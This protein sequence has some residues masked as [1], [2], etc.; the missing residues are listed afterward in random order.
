MKLRYLLSALAGIALLASCTEEEPVASYDLALKLDKS[1]V[2]VGS[3]GGS[4]T[5]E[6]NSGEISWSATCSADWVQFSPASGKGTT[7]VTVTIGASDEDRNAEIVLKA[8]SLE[9]LI[10]IIQTGNPHGLMEDD[11]LTCAEAA[12]ICLKLSSGAKTPKKY[13]VKGI[14]SSVVEAYGTQYGNGTW[15]MSDNGEEKTFEVYRAL[16]LNNEK[17]DDTSKQNIGEGDEVV[18][19][20]LLTNYNG[21]A[22]TSQNEAYLVS[23]KAGTDPVLS[24][25]EATKT[26][27]AAAEAATFEIVC[28]NLTEGWTVTGGADWITEFTQSGTKDDKEIKVKFA[29]NT[30]ETERTATFT[31]KSAGA[32]DLVLTLKQEAWSPITDINCADLNALEDGDAY[33]RVKGVITE[34]KMDKNDATKYN[35]Y[36]N[37]YIAD[38]TGVVYVYGLLPE[39]GGATKQDVLTTKGIKVGDLITVV[40][41]KGS[42]NGSPQMVNAYYEAHTPVTTTTCEAFN[43]LTDGDDLFLIKGTI[44]NIV[45]DKNDPTKYNKYG[46]FDVEDASGKVYVYGIVPVM[47]GKSGQD[48]LTTLGVK[49]GDIVTVVGPKASYNSNPQMKNGYLVSVEPGSSEEVPALYLNEFDTLNKKIEIYNSTDQEVDMTGWILSKDETEWTIPAEHAKVPAKGFIVYTG[50]SDGT[51]DPTFG[52]SG[53]KGFVVVLKKG[54]TIVDKVDNSSAR[55]GGIVVIED[56]KSWGRETDGAEKFVIFDTPT[57]GESNGA[58]PAPTPL[59][60]TEILA[61][62]KGA[63]FTAQE[64]LVVAKTTKGV[65]VS[66]GAKAVYAYG[67]QVDNVNIGDKIVFAGKKTVYNGVHELESLSGVEV[68]STGNAVTYPDPKDITA[69]VTTYTNT[70]AEYVSLTGQLAVSGNY[71]NL[72]IEGV[73]S[74]TKMGSIVYPIAA[75]NAADFDGKVITVTGYYNG[76]SGSN[77]YVNVIAT[78]IEEPEAPS[79]STGGIPD[80]DP[81]TGFTW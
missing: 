30:V 55:E 57:I 14:I 32:K 48:I 12:E 77:K 13:Y 4:A 72:T 60:I 61:L 54:E 79:S 81:L 45:M 69:E 39:A 80:Y 74:A 64:C 1:V 17:Y 37:F 43:A 25:K 51:T 34:I 36:G 22:E 58:E 7:K 23:I 62:D 15:W 66:D 11:P 70:E 2:A 73:D 10:T 35:A 44:K 16:Y 42:Y 28:Q 75:L 47:T 26:V 3:E 50:K 19:Y 49:E 20:G 52:L 67:T 76:L 40:G 78:K 53:T 31:V 21:T 59:T 71:Y 46:N 56:G 29:A 68:K 38:E 41:P 33:Y 24:C 5:V 65:V 27:P 18:V 8:E 9:R 6:V 63:E